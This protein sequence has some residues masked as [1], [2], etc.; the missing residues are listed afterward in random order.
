MKFDV[1][2]GNPPYQMNDGGNGSSAKPLYHFYVEQAQQLSSLCMTMITPARWYSGGKGLDD[3]REEMLKNKGIKVLSDYFDATECFPNIDISGGVCHFL[4]ERKYQGECKV[5]S[6]LNGKVSIQQR[7]L[8]ENNNLF[9]VRFNEAVTILRKIQKMREEKFI[10]YVSSRKPFGITTTIKPKQQD[11]NNNIK[12]YA[13]PQNGYISENDIV[14]NINWVSQYKIYIAK[15]YGERGNFPYL[16]IGKPFI[17]EP[18]S[19]CS[20]TYLVCY[21]TDN[22]K[23]AENCVS[24]L[25]T[26]F[27]RFLILLI[28]NT[29]NAAKNVYQFVPM[30]NF[31]ESWTD[32]KLYKKYGLNKEEINFIESMVRPME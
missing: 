20:E 9:F 25:K 23:K 24:Y 28:K 1:V 10:D 13:Y 26:K 31:D 6:H 29:Q 32:E 5:I 12:I 18:N 8:S 4:W 21:P 30:Q 27:A 3:F 15:A 17:G 16:V 14:Q 7:Y 11:K 22:K 19:C 2:I